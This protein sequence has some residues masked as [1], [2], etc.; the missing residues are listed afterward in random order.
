ERLIAPVGSALKEAGREAL[1]VLYSPVMDKPFS[2]LARQA[3]RLIEIV[4]VGEPDPRQRPAARG[5]GR[6]D[7]DHQRA[8]TT[9]AGL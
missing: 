7:T 9:L 5:P 1:V 8:Q 3:D 2:A 4:N 6:K